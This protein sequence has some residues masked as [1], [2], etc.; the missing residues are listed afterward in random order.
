[1][2]ADEQNKEL[3]K[4]KAMTVF[5]QRGQTVKYQYNIAGNVDLSTVNN[6]PEFLEQ[7]TKLQAEMKEAIEKQAIEGEEA[8]DAKYHLDKAVHEAEKPDPDK[9]KLKDHLLDAKMAIE[10]IAA[11]GGLIAAL[12]KAVE[13]VEK[14]F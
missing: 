7:L 4:E 10:G 14:L 8:T 6:S 3:P 11:V 5:D 12:T 9:K 1:M 2:Q 13:L